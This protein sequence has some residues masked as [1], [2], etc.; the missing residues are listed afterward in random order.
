MY[1]DDVFGGPFDLDASGNVAD[2]DPATARNGAFPRE[3]GRGVRGNDNCRLE[4]N[5]RQVLRSGGFE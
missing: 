3:A 5:L 4:R 2:P 1:F